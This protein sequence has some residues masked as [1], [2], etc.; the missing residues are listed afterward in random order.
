M[1]ITGSNAFC[2]YSAEKKKKFRLES[3]VR[4]KCKYLKKKKGGGFIISDP[5]DC[6]SFYFGELLCTANQHFSWS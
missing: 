1:I 2:N 6:V 5:N 3:E 4:F